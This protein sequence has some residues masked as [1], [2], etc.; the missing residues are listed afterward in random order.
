MSDEDKAIWWEKAIGQ[1]VRNSGTPDNWF[2]SLP[3]C[4]R[5]RSSGI[6]LLAAP[7][8]ENAQQPAELIELQYDHFTD[9]ASAELR[10]VR[11]LMS[12]IGG[13]SY[14]LTTTSSVFLR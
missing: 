5:D 2:N 4:L 12:Y 14:I 10:L 1:H 6:S 7:M 13:Y 8:T 9:E 3:Q 11:G